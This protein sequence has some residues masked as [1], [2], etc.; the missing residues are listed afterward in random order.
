MTRRV[1]SALAVLVVVAAIVAVVLAGIRPG[2]ARD[3]SAAAGA[4]RDSGQSTAGTSDRATAPGSSGPSSALTAT[5]AGRS[6]APPTVAPTSSAPPAAADLPSPVLAVA[7]PSAPPRAARVAAAVERPR[8]EPASAAYGGSVLDA[9]TGKV[10]YEHRAARG[11]VPAST[12]KLLTSGAALTALGPEHRFSTRVV[13]SR[14]GQVV[15][16]GGGDPYLARAHRSDHGSVA[17]LAVATAQG[18][19]R[20]GQRKVSLRY[21]T[22][23]F[24]GPSFSPS[25][26]ATYADQVSPITP[27]WVDQGRTGRGWAADPSRAAATAF[28]AALKHEGVRVTTVKPGHADEPATTLATVRSLPLRR[29]VEWLLLTS[30]N[31]AAEV[32]FRQ[33]AVAGGEPGSFAGGVRAVERRLRDLKLWSPALEIAD[34]SGLGRDNRIPPEALTGLLRQ[35]TQDGHRELRAILP[36]LP[37]AGV[38]GSLRSRFVDT[39]SQDG[40]GLVRAKTGTLRQVHALAGYVRSEDGSLMVFAFV[41]NG[42]GSEVAATVWLERVTAALSQCGCR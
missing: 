37:T 8:G 15:L 3:G 10:L 16:V 36:G 24:R 27:L 41:T 40:R 18:L 32:I 33:V 13:Q 2:L 14:R 17:D 1:E 26:P 7:H 4:A 29:I 42:A 21:D 11:L 20:D 25:W 38:E 23:L 22:S 28:A 6:P 31:N 35:A 19:R 30:D 9:D 12:M 39:A 34:G 5:P